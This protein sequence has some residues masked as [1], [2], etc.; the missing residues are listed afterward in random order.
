MKKQYDFAKA[1][2][3]PHAARLKKQVTMRIDETTIAFFKNMASSIGIPYQILMNL[4]LR[5]CAEKGKKLEMEF[6]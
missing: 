6:R 3:N 5:Q 4:Y 2:K 1:R